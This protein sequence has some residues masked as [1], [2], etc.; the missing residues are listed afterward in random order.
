MSLPCRDLYFILAK[1]KARVALGMCLKRATASLWLQPLHLLT[2]KIHLTLYP[3]L[4]KKGSQITRKEFD[5]L[6]Y[7]KTFCQVRG[8]HKPLTA[9]YASRKIHCML[10]SVLVNGRFQEPALLSL[11]IVWLKV[12]CVAVLNHCLPLTPRGVRLWLSS[13]A[14]SCEMFTSSQDFPTKSS[15]SQTS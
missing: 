11:L 9:A 3:A 1:S 15:S 6:V 10:Y 4:V 7:V 13:L 14:P 8:T 5:K 12:T 2:S